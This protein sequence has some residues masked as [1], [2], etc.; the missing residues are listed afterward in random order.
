MKKE[1]I[2]VS[3]KP[4]IR[5]YKHALAL[6]RTNNYYL[7]LIAF[8]IKPNFDF[9]NVFDEVLIFG[10]QEITKNKLFYKGVGLTLLAHSK[11]YHKK[12]AKIIKKENPNLFHTFANYHHEMSDIVMENT[13]VPVIYDGQD[14]LGISFGLENISEEKK[15]KEKYCFENADGIIRKGPPFEIDYYRQNGYKINCPELKFLPYCDKR[16]FVNGTKKLSDEDG[17]IHLVYTGSIENNYKIRYQYF[18]PLAKILAKQRIH[19][20]IYSGSVSGIKKRDYKKFK[21]YYELDKSEKYFHFHESVPFSKLHVGISKYDFGLSIHENFPMPLWTREK[22]MT[23]IG[24][25]FFSYLEASLPIIVSEHIIHNREIVEQYK[26]GFSVKDEELVKLKNILDKT[27]IEFFRS[28]VLNE[29]KRLTIN[30]N[31]NSLIEFYNLI[32]NS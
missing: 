12:L 20:H 31:S 32:E 8:E 2:F 1:I 27:N 3:L 17:E 30:Y 21:E 22:M 18:I 4:H 25:K 5:E 29:R 19:F 16:L 6:K 10:P 15:Q 7:K 9:D 28:N 26:V 13:N 14:F 11:Y 23:S 24:N